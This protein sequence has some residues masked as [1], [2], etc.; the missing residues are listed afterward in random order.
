MVGLS[1]TFV[2][3]PAEVSTR[4]RAKVAS[5]LAAGRRQNSRQES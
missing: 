3:T 5:Y 4:I 1:C 2:Q